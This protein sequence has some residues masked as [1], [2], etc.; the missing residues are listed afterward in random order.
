M[1]LRAFYEAV[2]PAEGHFALFLAG[3]KQHVWADSLDD[4]VAQTERVADQQGVYFATASF[5]EPTSRKAENVAVRRSFCFDIDAGET[6]FLKHGDKVYRT[7]KS[8]L[9]AVAQWIVKTHLLPRFIVSSG[10]GLHVYFTVPEALTTD[11]WLPLAE[12]L[13]NRAIADG[14]KIDPTVTADACRVLRPVGTPHSSGK[15]VAVL[16]KGKSTSLDKLRKV[17]EGFQPTPKRRSL[18]AEILEAPVGPPKSAAKIVQHCAAFAHVVSSR[19][20]VPEPYW[21][22][23][24]GLVKFTVEG[25]D[26]AHQISSG[27]PDYDPDETDSKL[28]RWTAGPTTCDT[29]AAENP[30]ACAGCRYR[31]KVK[32]PIMLG[33]L[34]VQ[35]LQRAPEP[36]PAQD[37][38]PVEEETAE[39]ERE[40]ATPFQ[41]QD[42]DDDEPQPAK[43]RHEWDKF[44]PEGFRIAPLNGGFV[45]VQRRVV[46]EEAVTGEGMVRREVDVPFC[47][48]PFWFDSWALGSSDTDQASALYRTY[49]PATKKTSSFTLP[50]RMVAKRD[51]LLT[52]LASQNIQVFNPSN[53]NL[54]KA[55]MEDY[56]KASLER[57][58]NAG[59]KPK[60]ADRFGTFFTHSGEMV[61]A[62]GAHLISKN[63]V[64]TEGVVQDKLRQRATAYRV[65]LPDNVSGVWPAEEWL[66][67]TMERAKRHVDYLREF[68][69]DPNFAPY[70]LAIMLAWAS[71]LLAFMQGTYHPGASLPGSGLTV[72]LFSVRSGI[73]KTAC[74]HAAALAFGS[75]NGIVLQLDR[76]NSTENARQ[77]LL[78][79]AGTMPAFMDEMENLDPSE[80]ASLVSAVGNGASKLRMTKE[81]SLVGGVTTA[82]VNIMST[83]KSHR[84]LVA[85]DRTESPAVQ[86]RLL[87][88]DCSEVSPVDPE[89]ASAEGEARS[90]LH[91]CAGAVGALLHLAMCRAGAAAL[92]KAGI[93]CADKARELVGGQQ[94]GRF[95]W[96]AFGA[97]LLARRLLKGLGLQVFELDTLTAEFRKWHDR[98]YDFTKQYILPSDGADLMSVFLADIDQYTLVTHG[99]SQRHGGSTDKVDLPLNDRMPNTVMAR[100]VLSGRYVYVRA[101]AFRDWC[102]KKRVSHQSVVQKCR[103]LG[104]FEPTGHSLTRQIDLYKG[105]KMA[106]GVRSTVYKIL[107]DKLAKDEP[108]ASTANVVELRRSE[109]REGPATA[110]SEQTA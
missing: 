24:L 47:N 88:I 9:R 7:Q 34:T 12:G 20:N 101:D 55:A 23:M 74:M 18:N 71:P 15:T 29:F 77:G 52:A 56:V 62:Q 21:R 80:I 19:G 92:N 5:N 2:L 40:E 94:D 108:A 6:K 104:V 3:R 50:T 84:E 54:A 37:S 27:H 102:A 11:E 4:L 65:Q 100:S 16:L 96:R 38:A 79:Q 14:L 26:M 60:I 39:P 67:P 63:G 59:Q 73:G 69:A 103:A 31:G 32:S 107:L 91:D 76:T 78:L 13:K 45:M 95:M 10:D 72:S 68:Y 93:E 30:E 87:E 1:S 83:N 58:R 70:Q 43:T 49:D 82:L 42:E 66:T 33:E 81:T 22:A 35:E 105:T 85:A 28:E 109:A 89:R 17:T 53:P 106:Q 110:A 36:E 44:L 75:P 41:S 46:V 99:E 48:V 97:V 90:K 25:A 98:G 64:I 8:A 57:I 61:I 86:M 51:T